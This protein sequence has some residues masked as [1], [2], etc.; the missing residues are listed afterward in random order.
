MHVGTR[1]SQ[2]TEARGIGALIE[3][4]RTTN[5]KALERKEGILFPVLRQRLGPTTVS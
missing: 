5:C 4:Q 1:K 3:K 2:D